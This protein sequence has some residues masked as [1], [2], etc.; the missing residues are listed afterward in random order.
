MNKADI[1][2]LVHGKLNGTKKSAEEAVDTVFDSITSSLSKGQEVSIS[3]F[4]TFVTKKRA[5]RQ[6]VNPRT[7]E[8]I[9][10]KATTTPKFRA[11]KGLKEA[12][13]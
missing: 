2:D 13:R 12:V 6:G 1:V 8:K 3:G 4:G 7:G 5:A 10:I 9:Q 11:G